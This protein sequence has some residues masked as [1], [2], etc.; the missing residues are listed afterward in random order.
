MVVVTLVA[1]S[2]VDA[3]ERLDRLVHHMLYGLEHV[4]ILSQGVEPLPVFR[5]HSIGVRIHEAEPRHGHVLEYLV[6]LPDNVRQGGLGAG[7]GGRASIVIL[8][9]L[10]TLKGGGISHRDLSPSD[11]GRAANH[12]GTDFRNQ[13]A[14][15]QGGR[16]N[17]FHRFK[18]RSEIVHL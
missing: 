5:P 8:H 18:N 14:Q 11:I 3:A 7:A 12:P 4:M 15:E 9:Q 1:V 13:R 10:A 2:T 16:R 6:L 17:E